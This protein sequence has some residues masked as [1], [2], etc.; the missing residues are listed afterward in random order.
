MPHPHETG[1]LA[2]GYER[3]YAAAEPHVRRQVEHEFAE[4]IRNATPDEERRLRGKMATL[5]AER[6]DELAPRDALY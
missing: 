4:R 5:I 2:D 3:A 6:I 1:G